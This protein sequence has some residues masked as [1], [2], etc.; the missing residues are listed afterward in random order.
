MRKLGIIVTGV[1]V[2]ALLAQKNVWPQVGETLRAA[3]GVIG[4]LLPL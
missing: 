2:V 4:A 3:L 1:L